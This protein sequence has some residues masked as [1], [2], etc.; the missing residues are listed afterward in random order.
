MF[1][2]LQ[3][4]ILKNQVGTALKVK[5]KMGVMAEIKAFL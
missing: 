4:E 1:A 5:K 3:E 2:Y